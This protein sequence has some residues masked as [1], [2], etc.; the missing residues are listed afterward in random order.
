[1]CLGFTERLLQYRH[2]RDRE[3]EFQHS[4]RCMYR[5]RLLVSGE[6][7]ALGLLGCS[8]VPPRT[9]SATSAENALG[10]TYTEATLDMF[11][12][13]LSESQ[14]MG[15]SILAPYLVIKAASAHSPI[16]KPS[17]HIV[18]R[19]ICIVVR[20]ARSS[21]KP[22]CMSQMHTWGRRSGCPVRKL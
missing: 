4:M 2:P 15:E 6:P 19:L 13:K 21:N 22:R 1:M 11:A 16:S 12:Y 14:S 5:T 8:R 7:D 10:Q 3:A 9:V 18:C 17:Q 20:G